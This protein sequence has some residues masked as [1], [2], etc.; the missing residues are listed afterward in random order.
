MD[1]LRNVV[2]LFGINQRKWDS[3]QN[4]SNK[5]C[6]LW[7]MYE[8]MALEF[9]KKKHKNSTV[10]HLNIRMLYGII[11]GYIID[12]VWPATTTTYKTQYCREWHTIFR[13]K[14]HSRAI[15]HQ[16]VIIVMLIEL[17]LNRLRMA[18]ATCSIQT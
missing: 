16:Y 9:S 13:I 17:K 5:L 2:L 3:F 18:S 8:R 6:R 4:R 12:S 11:Y 1:M 7:E 14:I 10:S 15:L